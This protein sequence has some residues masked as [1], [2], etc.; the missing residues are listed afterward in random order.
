MVIVPHNTP[1]R[2][3]TSQAS[4]KHSPSECALCKEQH[5]LFRCPVFLGYDI[6]KRTKYVKDKRG[7]TNCLSFNH[8]TAD[9]PSSFNCKDCNGR[10]N[11]LLHRASCSS[12]SSNATPASDTANLMV[13]NQQSSNS[14]IE[15]TEEPPRGVFLHTAIAKA[16]HGDRES[17][18][19][20]AL[21]TGASASLITENL[22]SSL[23]LKRY[24]R[25]QMISSA[26]GEEVSKYFVKLQLQSTTDPT[27]TIVIKGNVVKS[28]PTLQA[29]T[30]ISAIKAEPHLQG[31]QLADPSFGGHIDILLGGTHHLDCIVGSLTKGIYS[32][33]ATQPTIFGW[34]VTGPLDHATPNSSSVF[35]IQAT[36]DDLH[37]D[38]SLLWELDRTPEH[39]HMCPADEEVTQHFLDTHSIDTDGR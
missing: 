26:V 14:S 1:F 4:S 2:R 32:K 10:H 34:T 38:L 21:D 11:T 28:L 29:P 23:H 20:L 18:V 22:A 5:K 31:L 37:Q 17:T 16:I 30:N 27:K 15:D 13:I 35:Q 33:V 12:S 3:Q 36:K 19:R 9:C 7:C 39:S 25:R 6:A 24:S 8:G